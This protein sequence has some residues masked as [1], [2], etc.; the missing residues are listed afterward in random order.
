VDI[1]QKKQKKVEPGSP[2]SDVEGDAWIF[3][4]IKRESYLI[5][6]YEIGKQ[7]RESCK[8]LFEKV[9]DRVQLPFPYMKI[10]IFSDG[11]DDYTS[12]IPEYYAES[13][14]DY[15][16]VIKIR[17]RGK[18]VDK[19]KKVIYGTLNFDE[20]ETTDIENMNSISRERLGRLVRET[21]CFSK[22]KP[23]LINAFEL[24]HFYW[25]FMD[26]LTK[27]ETPAMLEG[28]ADY[29]WNWEQFFN[30]PLSILN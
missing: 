7:G 18:I 26:K 23:R 14:V 11:N 9:F 17:E 25:N 24:F 21:K 5:V 29:Q 20:I 19:I 1:H 3:N 22:K 15:G 13:C 30:F 8:K 6:A 12:T 28:L 10:Q 16:Q 27:S 2:N 4:F